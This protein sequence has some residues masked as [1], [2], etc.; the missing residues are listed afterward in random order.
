MKSLILATLL[1]FAGSAYAEVDC[2]GIG[3]CQGQQQAQGQ[4]QG[5]LQGQAQNNNQRLSSNSRANAGAAAG[6]IS[7]AGSGS[8]ADGYQAISVIEE[9]ERVASSAASLN[10]AYCSE[11]VSGQADQ[12]G[13]SLGNV[14]YICE[15]QMALQMHMIL[16][17]SAISGYE[18]HKDIDTQIADEHLVEAHLLLEE[19]KDMIRDV[20]SY[21][22]SRRNTA[23]IAAASRDA[24]F[25]VSLITL[26]FFLL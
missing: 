17:E 11:G 12:G 23:G 8:S 10:L 25:P 7:L 19:S 5:Q 18:T 22:N 13:F 4:L 2:F 14:A 16:V 1:L 6:A 21:I 3:Q 15:A 20:G 24:F 26:L 9:Y